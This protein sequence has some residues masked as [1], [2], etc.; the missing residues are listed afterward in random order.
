MRKKALAILLSLAMSFAMIGCGNSQNGAEA[1][2]VETQ[3]NAQEMDADQT[4]SEQNDLEQADAEQT[5]T[6]QADTEQTDSEQTDADQADTEQDADQADT[7][8]DADQVGTEQDAADATS[9]KEAA[10]DEE[11]QAEE[12]QIEYTVK[13]Y[14]EAKT[15]Y[16]S[17]KVN[18][19]KGPSTDFDA[20]GSLQARGEVSVTGQADTGWYEIEY[21]NEKAYVSDSY[22][23]DELPAEPEPAPG[24]DNQ[25]PAAPAPAPA[26]G[27]V[28]AA[29]M[30]M[31]GDSR[32]VQMH[33]AVGD[34]GCVWI[35]ENGKGYN[36]L[37]AEALGQI[38]GCVG[39]GT[40]VLFN[41]GVNDPGNINNYLALVNEKA[42]E[43]AARGARI[44][45]ATVNP[46][47]ENPYTTSE[48]VAY[49]NATLIAG[50][51][52]N[53]RII[54]SN[55]YISSA[56]CNVVDGLHYDHD[57]YVRLFNY[58]VGSCR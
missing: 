28:N 33:E 32:F 57:T 49:F 48:Q 19:R 56:G 15:M 12:K 40:R 36:W 26:P 1:S 21:K 14:S 27:P 39:K 34:Q 17:T 22:L 13:P 51:S 24:T 29:G 38:D 10:S 2:A 11:A 52:G 5:D 41:L 6:E 58:M 43:W 9:A 37:S 53:V 20:V 46:V 31:V 35:C 16:A 25:D 23:V 4:G 3:T 45:Y 44:Y 54:D 7:E 47:T 50:H 8:Q 30:V 42:A 18:I 55:S